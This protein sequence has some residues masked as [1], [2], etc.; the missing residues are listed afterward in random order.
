[1]V[2]ASYDRLE[3]NEHMWPVNL[4]YTVTA[5]YY[6]PRYDYIELKVYRWNPTKSKVTCQSNISSVMMQTKLNLMVSNAYFDS[7]KELVSNCLLKELILLLFK[8][9]TINT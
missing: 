8:A 3:I 4:N 5:N 6:A 7:G 9:I 1:M 2:I